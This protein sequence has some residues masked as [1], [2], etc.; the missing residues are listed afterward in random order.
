MTPFFFVFGVRNGEL[1]NLC[2]TDMIPLWIPPIL[3]QNVKVRPK[4]IYTTID[5]VF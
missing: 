4:G 5:V 2:P 3:P 1:K